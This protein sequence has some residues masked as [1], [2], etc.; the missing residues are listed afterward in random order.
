[1]RHV[2]NQVGLEPLAFDRRLHRLPDAVPNVVQ[3][4]RDVTVRSGQALRLHLVIGVSGGH[5][6]HPL[7]DT[8]PAGDTF[9]RIKHR[10]HICRQDEH[11]HI[12]KTSHMFPCGIREQPMQESKPGHRHRGPQRQFLVLPEYPGKFPN[13]SCDGAEQ[14]VFPE[15]L[16]L[17]TAYEA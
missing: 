2:G 1:M 16:S 12:E 8:L 4:F 6:L 10:R 3:L 17:D 7:A 5:F 14:A 15:R 13:P 11:H 9:N